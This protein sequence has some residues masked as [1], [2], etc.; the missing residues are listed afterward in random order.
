LDEPAG[1]RVGRTAGFA[2][3]GGQ[4]GG[5]TSNTEAMGGIHATHSLMENKMSTDFEIARRKYK[6][7]SIKF[8]FVAEA[9][10][11][12]ESG[13]FFYFENVSDKD[14]LFLEM[15]KVLY[16]KHYSVT[17]IA[18]FRKSSFSIDSSLMDST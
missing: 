17:K 11:K 8:L 18:A 12:K 5:S 7:Q 3:K 6:P 16:P 10:P 2:L 4:G 14:S 15:M 13:R 1:R 9:P